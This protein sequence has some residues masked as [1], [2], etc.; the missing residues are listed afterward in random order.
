MMRKMLRTTGS[1]AASILLILSMVTPSIPFHRSIDAPGT[2]A[3]GRQIEAGEAVH[4]R[5][6]AAVDQRVEAFWRVNHEI[7]DRHFTREN[8]GRRPRQQAEDQKRPADQLNE[9]GG[10]E[11]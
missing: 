10:T 6:R 4:D 9:A 5:K 1:P 3:R 7:G 11:Q 8:E 2:G